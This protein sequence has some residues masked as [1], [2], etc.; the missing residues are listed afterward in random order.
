MFLLMQQ[1]RLPKV[2]LPEDAAALL[3]SWGKSKGAE[4]TNETLLS[5]HSLVFE[6]ECGKRLSLFA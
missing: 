1:R 3:K 2:A 5:G 4:L 6:K